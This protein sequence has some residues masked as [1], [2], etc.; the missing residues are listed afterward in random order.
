VLQTQQWLWYYCPVVLYLLLL[1]L[2]AVADMTE[3][4][5]QSPPP[6]DARRALVVVGAIFLLPL[7]AGLAYQLDGF[8]DPTLLSIQQAN[9]DAGEL[10]RGDVPEDAVLASWDAGVVGYFSHRKVI[11][12]D[13][14]VN[15][16]EFYD[17]TRA[18]TVAA[19]LR[20][21][22]VGFVV[23]HGVQVDGRDP[24]IEK[25]IEDL[26]GPDAR[27]GATMLHG[28]PFTYSGTTNTGGFDLGGEREL[29][30]DVYEI[31]ASSINV[32]PTDVCPAS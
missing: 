7:A 23:N 24:D 10:I 29:S 17:A 16:K 28:V 31:P 2:L 14:V 15:S 11:N 12:I 1:F 6:A 26:Y 9:R 8:T 32:R 5:L 4:A 3:V 30:V 27:R 18:G 22:R 20:C 21:R 19:F 13:G 25:L